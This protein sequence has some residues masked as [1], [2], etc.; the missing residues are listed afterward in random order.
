MFNQKTV[1]YVS[2]QNDRNCRRLKFETPDLYCKEANHDD[3]GFD[4]RII[5]GVKE[6]IL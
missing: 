2:I 5:R 3:T 1:F 4:T 6:C